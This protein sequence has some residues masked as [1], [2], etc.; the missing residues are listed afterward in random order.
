[1]LF[2]IVLRTVWKY[3]QCFWWTIRSI[4]RFKWWLCVSCIR[5]LCVVYFKICF[6]GCVYEKDWLCSL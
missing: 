3:L 4:T 1:M 5:F 2:V 6:V